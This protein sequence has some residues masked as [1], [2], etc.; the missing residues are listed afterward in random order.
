MENDDYFEDEEFSL[1][2]HSV[3]KPFSEQDTHVPLILF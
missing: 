3:Q 2:V 1:S